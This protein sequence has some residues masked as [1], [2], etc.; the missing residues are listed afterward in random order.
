M[1]KHITPIKPSVAG[2]FVGCGGLDSGFKS[3]GYNIEWAN[4]W[5]SDAAKTYMSFIGRHVVIGDIWNHLNEIPRV[6]VVIGGPPCQAFSL[7]GKRLQD[8]P[9]A[10]LVFAFEQAIERIKPRA[11]VM[12]NVPGLMA[13]TIDGKS[14]TDYLTERFVNLGYIVIILK[15]T[16]TDFFVPQKRQRVLMV[17]HRFH[18]KAFKLIDSRTLAILLGDTK[19]RVPIS[20]AEALDDLPSPLPK[21]SDAFALYPTPPI[22]AYS[23]LMRQS[24]SSTVSLQAMPTMSALDRE[25]VRHIPPG[26]NY[27]NIPD[28]ISTKRITTFKR[29]GGRTTTYGRL[30]PNKPAYTI[31]TYFN[32]PNVGANYHH[33]EERLITVREALR[34]QSFPDHFIPHFSNQR[35]LHMQIGNAVP[36]LMS[37][38]IAESLKS[39]F[40]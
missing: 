21:R 26:G 18:G 16:A 20:V 30:H 14:L 40:L 1:R 24:A 34:L 33:R 8:D 22:T 31:N 17:G 29:T 2:L 6:D 25:F 35:S 32:R 37:Q 27:M 36:P 39:L 5:A 15:L 19:L 13:S 10:Q 11:F 7:V 4:E 9:R 12:E 23:R 28:N 38:A 3:T